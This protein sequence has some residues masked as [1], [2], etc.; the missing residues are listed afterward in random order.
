MAAVASPFTRADA[1]SGR[2]HVG[3]GGVRPGPSLLATAIAVAGFSLTAATAGSAAA[4]PRPG[5]TVRSKASIADRGATRSN[6]QAQVKP[7]PPGPTW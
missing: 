4:A 2:L 7:S 3:P 1:L 5:S 6:I